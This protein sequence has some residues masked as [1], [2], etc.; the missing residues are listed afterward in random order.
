MVN[1]ICTFKTDEDKKNEINLILDYILNKFSYNF[2]GKKLIA[3][4]SSFVI[5]IIIICLQ[6]YAAVNKDD[7]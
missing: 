3:E 2:E 5:R 4:T 1:I 6:S 7:L